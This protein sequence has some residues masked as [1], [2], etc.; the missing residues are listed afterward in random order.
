MSLTHLFPPVPKHLSAFLFCHDG[1]CPCSCSLSAGCSRVS[2][3][4]CSS[5]FEHSVVAM[6]AACL[7]HFCFF[8]QTFEDV[9]KFANCISV[10]V[11]VTRSS[12]LAVS[13]WTDWTPVDA[14][15]CVPQGY[16]YKTHLTLIER[17]SIS[18]GGGLHSFLWHKDK[19]F[20][21]LF[22]KQLPL[23]EWLPFVKLIK[24]D[25]VWESLYSVLN[26]PRGLIKRQVRH[27][28][29]NLTYIRWRYNNSNKCQLS[30]RIGQAGSGLWILS[31]D[32]LSTLAEEVE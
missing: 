4:L 11:Q 8:G 7:G 20:V 6:N 29:V 9:F 28:E 21:P 27:P 13:F 15:Q 25:Q 3:W 32:S 1:Q 17:Q 18:L 23:D 22:P 30:I 10:V 12:C 24:W 2:C 5:C 16:I 19:G 14:L 31:K 26:V